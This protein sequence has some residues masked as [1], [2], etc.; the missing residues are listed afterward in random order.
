M[1]N[2]IKSH[3]FNIL[4]IVCK[5][6]IPE[7]LYKYLKKEADYINQKRISKKCDEI[8]KL[9]YEGKT[10]KYNIKAKKNLNDEKII[11]QFWGQGWEYEKL[12]EIVRICYKSV[13]KYKGDYNVI[14]IDEKSMKDYIDFPEFILEKL[15]NKQMG[16]THFTDILRL[17][18][19]DVYGGV[20]LDATVL[21]TDVIDSK[22]EETGYFAF[23]RS[24]STEDKKKWID[25]NYTYFSWDK[26][27][28]VKVLSS[29]IFSKKGNIVIHT[30]LD[31]VLNFWEKETKVPHYFFF[32]I[33]YNELMEK[34]LKDQ[35]CPLI[36]DTL[37]HEF[38]RILINKFSEEEL[39]K[40]KE[41]INIHKLTHKLDIK[42][43][44]KKETFYGYLLNFLE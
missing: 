36:D 30:W 37:P 41:K 9:Y 21:L 8:I 14:R 11:W 38:S 16:Y 29:I 1:K 20:W 27:D 6:I 44:Q 43:E 40:I 39:Y 25:F 12:P 17:A 31:L 35:K 24:D 23:Q 10:E 3:C 5:T 4:R 42:E 7:K 15:K 32:Q 22:Y 13:E 34:Y 28:K 19:L 2:N 18:L 26:R 33:L